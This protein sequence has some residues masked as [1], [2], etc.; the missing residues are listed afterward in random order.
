MEVKLEAWSPRELY[1]RL[2]AAIVEGEG[3]CR[4][5]EEGWVEDGRGRASEREVSEWVRKV[6]EGR[7]IVALRKERRKRWDEGRV[8]GWR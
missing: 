2:G 3:N 1:N 8:G 4:A 7:R 6:R 5:V